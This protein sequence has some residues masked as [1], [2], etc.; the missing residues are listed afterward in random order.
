MPEFQIFYERNLPH[1]Q[2]PGA[3][4]FLTYR[5]AGSIPAQKLWELKQESKRLEKRNSALPEN[6]ETAEQRYLDQRRLFGKWDG[7]LDNCLSGPT[8]LKE[9]EVASLVSDSLKFLHQNMVELD[10]F[11]IM[12]NH[13]HAIFTPLIDVKTGEYFSLRKIMQSHKGY[14][15]KTCNDVLKRKGQFWQHESYDHFVRDINELKRIRK[16]V[17]LNPVK[18]GLVE[19]W[20]Q[21]PWTY[22]RYL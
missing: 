20:D 18:A 3:T 4:L 7:F 6:Q 2:P 5:L 10:T 16:Y 19:Y 21:W 9:Q 1:I 11:T 8:W 12:P 17:T 15:A 13:V 14:T 22:S